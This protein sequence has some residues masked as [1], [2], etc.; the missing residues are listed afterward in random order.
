MTAKDPTPV[1][2]FD[3]SGWGVGKRVTRPDGN[4]SGTIVE[5]TGQIKVKW[6]SGRTSY[7]KPGRAGNVLLKPPSGK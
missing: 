2:P 7:F 5:E 3:V 6:D 1:M 4:D